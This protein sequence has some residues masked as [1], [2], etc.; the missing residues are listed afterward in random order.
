MHLEFETP[1][2]NLGSFPDIAASKGNKTKEKP[3]KADKKGPSGKGKETI[4]GTGGKQEFPQ[5][6]G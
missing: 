2:P 1:T 3:P 6:A 4:T 5:K